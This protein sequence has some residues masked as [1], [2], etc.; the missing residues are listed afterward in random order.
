MISLAVL[1]R[2]K[3]LVEWWGDIW[4]EWGGF[5][6]VP[7]LLLGMGVSWYFGFSR[8][9]EVFVSLL[10]VAVILGILNLFLS[11]MGGRR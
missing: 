6:I 2:S 9:F 5:C 3:S 1:C 4:Y 7:F 11:I 10:P 8:G